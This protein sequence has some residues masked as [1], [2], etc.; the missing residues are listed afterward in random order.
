MRKNGFSKVDYVVIMLGTNDIGG[1]HVEKETENIGTPTLEEILAYMPIEFKKM[2]DSIREF[3]PN[4]KIGLNP[5]VPAGQN[6][7]FN[8]KVMKYTEMMQYHFDEKIPN[9]YCLGSYLANGKLSGKTW[10]S[11]QLTQVD[12][13]NETKRGQI[14]WDVH[15]AGNNQMLNTL[16]TASWIINQLV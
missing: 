6:D 15:D 3:D 2:I 7:S 11:N 4:I 16:W 10:A 5:P 9:V 12:P 1:Y 8:S 14:S 13:Y